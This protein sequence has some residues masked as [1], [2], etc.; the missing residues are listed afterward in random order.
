MFRSTTGLSISQIGMSGKTIV[1][2]F[3][4]GLLKKL[5][6]LISKEQKP[7]LSGNLSWQLSWTTDEL[8]WLANVPSSRGA[9]ARILVKSFTFGIKCEIW[10]KP[11][12]RVNI[13]ISEGEPKIGLGQL[14]QTAH[15]IMLQLH[16][17][18]KESLVVLNKLTGPT[19]DFTILFYC[20]CNLKYFG[21]P[22]HHIWRRYD[23]IFAKMCDSKQNIAQIGRVSQWCQTLLIDSIIGSTFCVA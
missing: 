11:S 13:P 23:V 22:W 6:V 5:F 9:K 2:K 14:L 7:G 21:M 4:L 17:V 12:P 10:Y 20:F 15:K 3:I 8:G 18:V 16:L 1:F 19:G